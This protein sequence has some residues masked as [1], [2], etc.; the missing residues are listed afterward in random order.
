[1]NLVL[2]TIE[3]VRQITLYIYYLCVDKLIDVHSAAII[4]QFSL[5]LMTSKLHVNIYAVKSF[6]CI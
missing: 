6:L 5:Q 4:I 2:I 1:M 3:F